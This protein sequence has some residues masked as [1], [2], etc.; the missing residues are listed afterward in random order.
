MHYPET[1]FSDFALFPTTLPA[2]T[3]HS[4]S[5]MLAVMPPR[6]QDTP[7]FQ[8][9]TMDPSMA[10]L[11]TLPMDNGN[12]FGPNHDS[13]RVPTS[14][15]DTHSVYAEDLQKPTAYPPM[16]GSPPVLTS[17][18]PEPHLPGL[19]SASGPSLDSTPSSVIGSPYSNTTQNFQEGW[20]DT[21]NGLG[22]VGAVVGDPLAHDYMGST[23]DPEAF[24]QKGCSDSF[25]SKFYWSP[26]FRV[27]TRFLLLNAAPDPSL[28]E[29]LPQQPSISSP[30]V[31]YSEQPNY[32]TQEPSFLPQTPGAA[33][34]L[35]I[36]ET[37]HAETEGHYPS[38][39]QPLSPSDML[40]SN[41]PYQS[42][43]DRRSSVS[44][45]QTGGSRHSPAASSPGNDD[46]P[47][48]KGRCPHPDCGRPV[49]DLK[50]H[51]LSHL[52]ERPEKCPLVNCEWHVKGF[53]RKY[54]KNRHT[55]THYKGTMVCGFCP[56]SGSPAEKSF[57]R[58]DVFKRHLTAVHGVEQTPPNCRKKNPSA[59]ARRDA[60]SSATNATG[61]CSECAVTFSNPQDLYEHLDD[62]CL[63]SVQQE[64]PTES[65]NQQRL[66]EVDS[67]V[68]LKKTME[69]HQL[70]DTAGPCDQYDDDHE[71]NDHEGNDLDDSYNNQRSG[72]GSITKSIKGTQNN[73]PILGK[74]NAV[75]KS[76]S[77]PTTTTN[78]NKNKNNKARPVV[79]R[80]RNNR[81]YYPQS[82]GCPSS[83]M[84]TK[85]RVL[86]VFDGP[87]RL[88]K[89]EMMLDNEFEVRL[90]LPG[91]AG[92]GTNRDVYITDLDVETLKRADGV[93][94]ATAA[95]R[96]PWVDGPSNQFIGQPA[97]PLPGLS[98]PEEEIVGV[99]IDELMA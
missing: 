16:P 12:A 68:E 47:R 30:T 55:L 48:E 92:D 15:Y 86:C 62:C 2:T 32:M 66:A 7:F 43:Q 13:A 57:N 64:K 60:P 72:K 25:V 6:Q 17:Q 93:L 90:Q 51:M 61:K 4:Q 77:K 20:T 33:S 76:S 54:D 18:A 19:S 5:K 91:G 97:R 38:D 89:D 67:D 50:S 75:T 69:K 58:T 95:E 96:G 24:Y 71:G 9:M 41:P 79:S 37:L 31:T 14:Y 35:P 53:A 56:G 99:N 82:W 45:S 1:T 88:W 26:I 80:R 84:K 27:P 73:R 63:R 10:D 22:L 39:A 78:N 49:R 74:N 81:D 8:N 94:S 44:S 52:S 36:L 98:R 70:I 28:I 23:M 34:P 11:F 3:V 21:S 46:E 29:A 59:A 42:V 85:K 87:R 65:I 83:S 40:P